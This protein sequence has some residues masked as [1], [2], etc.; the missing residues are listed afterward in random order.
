MSQVLWLPTP[1]VTISEC[2]KPVGSRVQ[3]GEP[4]ATVSGGLMGVELREVM[5]TVVPGDR[6]LVVD[7]VGVG[8]A[9]DGTVSDPEALDTL[10]RTPSVVAAL[11][12]PEPRFMGDYVLTD[13]VTAYPVP[14]GALKMSG[15]E[16]GC[17]Q[18]P[19]GKGWRVSLLTSSMGRSY[20]SFGDAAAPDSVSLHPADD[21]TC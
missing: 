13:P 9:E 3:D 15:S 6:K 8:V 12:N 16:S 20:V 5:G 7:G 17:V 10:A 21:L 19:D 14:P 18:G 1:S 11:K 4:V 2:L